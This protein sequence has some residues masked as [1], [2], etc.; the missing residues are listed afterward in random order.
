[1]PLLY[2]DLRQY[3]IELL[4]LVFFELAA[5]CSLLLQLKAASPALILSLAFGISLVGGFVFSFRSV[6]SEE[7]SRSMAFLL[8]LPLIPVQIV[9]Q[10]F[11]LNLLLTTLNF[12]LV[13][14]ALLLYCLW[15]TEHVLAISPMLLT[16]WLLQLLN[17]HLFLG[18]ALLFSSNKAIWL[19][20]PLLLIGINLAANWASIQRWFSWVS[21]PAWG[22]QLLLLA[23]VL[24]LFAL[25]R[26]GYASSIA[27]REWS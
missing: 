14:G 18:C 17:N 15:Q 11:L 2:K 5:V 20:F 7:S 16:L 6:A 3:G 8:A 23:A 19:P 1:M 21:M 22:Y 13:F 9:A 25:C 26:A 12:V 10:K 27:S 24:A 4:P